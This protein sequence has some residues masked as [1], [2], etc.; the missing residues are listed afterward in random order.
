MRKVSNFLMS[1]LI[2]ASFLCN[3]S[4][5]IGQTPPKSPCKDNE[6]FRQF[7]FWD[8][9]WRVETPKGQL[10]GHNRVEVILDG[11]VLLE[12]WT[13]SGPSRGKSFNYYSPQTKK[14]HQHWVDNFG[15]SL[16]FIGEFKDNAIHF[17]GESKNAKGE[18]IQNK[19]TISKVSEK[20]VRQLWEQSKDG[21]NWIVA[22][23]GKYI[24]EAKV[25]DGE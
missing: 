14:W 11:C 17:K 18:T 25:S 10:A 6:V 16:E 7:D 4:G 20:E 5:L 23:D 13:G 3:A 19:M 1:F 8:G 2:I 15:N 12:N 21:E 24:K 9:N 22:F